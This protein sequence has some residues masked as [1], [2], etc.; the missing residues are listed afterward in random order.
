[1]PP[2]RNDF[3]EQGPLR[4]ERLITAPL[5]P[6]DD[7]VDD[8]LVALLIEAGGIAAED[9]RQLLLAQAD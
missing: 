5:G 2:G 4:I 3:T 1:L 7:G 6:G 8:H 9:H